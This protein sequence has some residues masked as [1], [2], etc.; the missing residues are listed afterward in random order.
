MRHPS[1]PVR[2]PDPPAQYKL[3]TVRSLLMAEQAAVPVELLRD[4]IFL[5]HGTACRGSILVFLPEPADIEQLSDALL[6]HP[7]GA[8]LLLCPLHALAA[9][10]QLQ[11]AFATDGPLRKV[12][13]STAVCEASPLPLPHPPASPPPPA[14]PPSPPPLPPPPPGPSPPPPPLVEVP[15]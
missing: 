1:Y 11:C 13:L 14:P 5:F 9:P 12:I 3:D 10:T 6:L 2:H 15:H 7:L 8:E 4:L